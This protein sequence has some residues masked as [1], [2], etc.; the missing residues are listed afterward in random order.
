MNI[1]QFIVNVVYFQKLS[2]GGPFQCYNK[3]SGGERPLKYTLIDLINT[4]GKTTSEMERLHVST[5]QNLAS[6]DRIAHQA[7]SLPGPN[8]LSIFA[9]IPNTPDFCIFVPQSDHLLSSLVKY[10]VRVLNVVCH[11]KELHFH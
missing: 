10:K 8:L 4:V 5:P 2:V 9:L 11:A 3:Q 1:S 6:F 7:W